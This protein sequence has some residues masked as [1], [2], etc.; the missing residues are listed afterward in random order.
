MLSKVTVPIV[1]VSSGMFTR[2]H[3]SELD[4]VTVRNHV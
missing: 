2:G 3:K 1:M 4:H